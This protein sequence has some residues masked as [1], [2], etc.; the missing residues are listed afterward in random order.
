MS[1]IEASRD[2]RVH[3]CTCTFRDTTQ[4]VNAAPPVHPPIRQEH[5]L[6]LNDVNVLPYVHPNDSINHLHVQV[7][8]EGTKSIIKRSGRPRVL[9]P[10]IN[11]DSTKDQ[12]IVRDTAGSVNLVHPERLP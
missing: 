6:T 2:F 11:G 12:D 5:L 8:E 10:R 3:S 4:S 7:G 9:V 1:S